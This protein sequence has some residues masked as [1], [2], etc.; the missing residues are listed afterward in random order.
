M[1]C[2]DHDLGITIYHMRQLDQKFTLGSKIITIE[3]DNV[4]FVLKNGF[5]NNKINVELEVGK[6]GTVFQ[7]HFFLMFKGTKALDEHILTYRVMV[8]RVFKVDGPKIL[9]PWKS[10]FT[11]R[12]VFGKVVDSKL[13]N[14][15][16]VELIFMLIPTVLRFW[17]QKKIVMNISNL[18]LEKGFR[19]QARMNH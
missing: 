2:V 10:L 3:P 13:S 7:D 19:S 14:G 18:R 8:D 5:K 4:P 17:N 15:L 9:N 12:Y 1:V 6:L 16:V 11:N